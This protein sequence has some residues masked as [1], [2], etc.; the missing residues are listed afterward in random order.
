MPD[1]QNDSDNPPEA[2][3]YSST[4]ADENSSDSKETAAIRM[5][6]PGFVS[7]HDIGLGDAIHSLTASVGIQPCGGC[8][9][10]AAKLNRLVSFRK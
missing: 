5:R 8:R 10:R 7:D 1:M 3:G 4:A 9:R 6:I 2:P